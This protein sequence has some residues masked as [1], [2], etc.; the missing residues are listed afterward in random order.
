VKYPKL[1]PLSPVSHS[2][3]IHQTIPRGALFATDSTAWTR[4]GLKLCLTPNRTCAWVD[5][6]PRMGEKVIAAIPGD[7]I[8]AAHSCPFAVTFDSLISPIT[9][10]DA[11][12]EKVLN[13]NPLPTAENPLRLLPVRS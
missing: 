5:A 3:Q 2:K 13:K 7:S 10:R 4:L 8:C 12:S 6:N 9:T 1:R 11:R